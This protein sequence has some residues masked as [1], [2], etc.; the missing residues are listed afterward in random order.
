M[1]WFPFRVGSLSQDKVA[2]VEALKTE[3]E[4]VQIFAPGYVDGSIEER[5][6]GKWT[7]ISVLAGFRMSEDEFEL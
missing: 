5:S 2:D 4:S 1:D 6:V 3:T 7:E